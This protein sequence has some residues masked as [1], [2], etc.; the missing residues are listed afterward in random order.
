MSSINPQRRHPT[1]TRTLH[2][3]QARWGNAINFQP[4]YFDSIDRKEIIEVPWDDSIRAH[5]RINYLNTAW[6]RRESMRSRMSRPFPTWSSPGTRRRRFQACKWLRQLLREAENRG[7]KI[8]KIKIRHC[9]SKQL[10]KMSS[11]IASRLS[12]ARKNSRDCY[13][14][15]KQTIQW[16]RKT[17]L[18][19][20]FDT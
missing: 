16:R 12:T 3:A 18:N 2:L 1:P 10:H 13:K 7:I 8:M 11:L 14:I 4:I 15:C 5:G 17:K 19:F 6:R 20:E 9:V